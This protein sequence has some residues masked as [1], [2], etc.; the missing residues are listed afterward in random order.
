[1]GSASFADRTFLESHFDYLI[2]LTFIILA[3]VGRFLMTD[4]EISASHCRIKIGVPYS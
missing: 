1:M 3:I 4:R 2:G